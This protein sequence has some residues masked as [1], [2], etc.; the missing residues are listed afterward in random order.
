MDIPSCLEAVRELLESSPRVAPAASLFS[1]T[2]IAGEAPVVED[3]PSPSPSSPLPPPLAPPP[4]SRPRLLIACQRSTST[5]RQVDNL[6]GGRAGGREG[7]LLSGRGF[8]ESPPASITVLADRC[9]GGRK[10]V[11][12]LLAHELVHATDHLVHTLDLQTCG[13]LACSELRAAGTAE[14]AGTWPA[15]LRRRCVRETAT[16]S[17]SMVF[18]AAQGQACVEATFEA[19]A[20]TDVRTDVGGVVRELAAAYDKA[21]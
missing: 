18:G 20:S 7:P 8:F 12:E 2:V 11:E 19:C 4:P 13:G 15:W 10:E 6:G 16:K 21:A 17:T 5:S 1:V 9:A 3:I 14:C